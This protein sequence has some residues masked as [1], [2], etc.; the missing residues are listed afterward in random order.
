MAKVMRGF[1][2]LYP[3]YRAEDVYAMVADIESYPA[4]VPGCRKARILSRRGDVWSVENE[5]G[6][7]P[8]HYRFVSRATVD[9]PRSLSIVSDDGPWRQLL[10]TWRFQPAGLGCLLSF[11]MTLE[12]SGFLAVAAT[13]VVADA[14]QRITRAFEGRAMQLFSENLRHRIGQP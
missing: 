3:H 14:E 2:R 9:P 4:F 5:Y 10:M 1:E 6:F 12:M 13:P 8:M 7:G 11:A